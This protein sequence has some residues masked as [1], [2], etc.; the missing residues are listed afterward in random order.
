[1][2]VWGG[3][4]KGVRFRLKFINNCMYVK[5]ATT[6]TMISSSLPPTM[7]MVVVI[8]TNAV[9]EQAQSVPCM[10]RYHELE[11]A[12]YCNTTLQSYEQGIQNTP[13]HVPELEL[14]RSEDL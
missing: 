7:S 6:E 3:G 4:C 5:Y 14:Q 8:P 10:Y 2:C 13:Y 12:R 1:M 11:Q 9:R